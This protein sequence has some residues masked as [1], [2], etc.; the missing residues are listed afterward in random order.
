MMDAMFFFYFECLVMF[1]RLF[2]FVA[3]TFPFGT[4][5]NAD[6]VWVI[7]IYIK[8]AS[9]SFKLYVRVCVIVVSWLS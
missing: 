9:C 7:F 2:G 3:V 5:Q 6:Y 4:H 8:L 1:A